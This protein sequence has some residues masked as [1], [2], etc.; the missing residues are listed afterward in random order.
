M[1]TTAEG[2]L[3]IRNEATEIVAIVYKDPKTHHNLIYMCAPAA[4]EEIERL[5]NHKK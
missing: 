2:V 4:T 1:N 3:V 5:L